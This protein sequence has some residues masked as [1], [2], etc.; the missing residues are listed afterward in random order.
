MSHMY[1]SFMRRDAS[2]DQ[3]SILNALCKATKS[4]KHV[5]CFKMADEKLIDPAFDKL[6]TKVTKILR[7]ARMHGQ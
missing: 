2:I 4:T 6:V 7:H 5:V 1:A 3:T